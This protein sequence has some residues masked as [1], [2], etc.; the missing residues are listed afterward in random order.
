MD[1]ERGSVEASAVC[2]SAQKCDDIAKRL[3][4]RQ[5]LAQRH[6]GSRVSSCARTWCIES[7]HKIARVVCFGGPVA[8]VAVYIVA[9]PRGQH[10]PA[11]SSEQFRVQHR[12]NDRRRWFGI[13]Q[14]PLLRIVRVL[15][16]VKL[17]RLLRASRIL[18]R[19]ETRVAINYGLLQIIRVGFLTVAL[20]H[21][22]A[23]I[24]AL[25]TVIVLSL[26]HI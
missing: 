14:R 25:Q 3:L 21:I 7:G 19:W 17:A 6:T 10:V 20:A 2:W 22:S 12:S 15:R 9:C 5:A 18:K 11:P 26:I 1:L 8:R 13:A 4:S 24:W 16:L 23:C